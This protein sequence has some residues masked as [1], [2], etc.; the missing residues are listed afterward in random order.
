MNNV[1]RFERKRGI[2]EVLSELRGRLD[3]IEVSNHALREQVECIET[4]VRSR[5]ALLRVEQGNVGNR[6]KD[7]R[8]L[9]TYR[10]KRWAYACNVTGNK[11]DA[12]QFAP[13]R[14]GDLILEDWPV[15]EEARLIESQWN[16]IIEHDRT[17]LPQRRDSSL[18]NNDQQIFEYGS[19]AF[20]S[21][22]C[23]TYE[24]TCVLFKYLTFRLTVGSIVHIEK[25]STDP[26]QPNPVVQKGF[27]EWQ[28]RNPQFKLSM[29]EESDRRSSFMVMTC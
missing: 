23:E 3:R 11:H 26:G 2:E 4:S 14:V 25:W 1:I 24:A 17:V 8:I 29:R 27:Q 6:F 10:G 13:L 28:D 20:A 22:S 12:L 18:R 5:D 9:G 21:I 15:S 19:V 7:A 16:H